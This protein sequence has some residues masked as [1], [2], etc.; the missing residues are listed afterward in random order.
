MKSLPW[1]LLRIVNES[2]KSYYVDRLAGNHELEVSF[3]EK[4]RLLVKR[5]VS[6]TDMY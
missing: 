2:L 5:E 4:E 3:G 1:T 6:V